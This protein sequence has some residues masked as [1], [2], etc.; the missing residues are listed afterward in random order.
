MIDGQGQERPDE[1]GTDPGHRRDREGNH[2]PRGQVHPWI[3]QG[4]R[5][6]KGSHVAEGM[7][8][9]YSWHAASLKIKLKHP[10]VV[11]SPL[12]MLS[13]MHLKPLPELPLRKH[14]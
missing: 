3:R 13:S 7:L 14:C 2:G 5:L 10:F 1:L 4:V 11:M 8:S 6:R 12:F 9:N